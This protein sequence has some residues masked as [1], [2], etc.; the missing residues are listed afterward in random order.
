[1]GSS[2][3]QRITPGG[4]TGGGLGPWK[5]WTLFRSSIPIHAGRSKEMPAK[6]VLIQATQQGDAWRK[7]GS[8]AEVAIEVP[9]GALVC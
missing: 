1:M 8:E 7:P 9:P 5:R 2:S 3:T 6:A 4:K